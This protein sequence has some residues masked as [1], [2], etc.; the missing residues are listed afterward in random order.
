M[1]AK[2]FERFKSFG[3]EKRFSVHVELSAALVQL[4]VVPNCVG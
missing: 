1:K 4:R 2:V 3:C